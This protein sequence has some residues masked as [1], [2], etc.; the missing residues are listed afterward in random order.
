MA[1]APF[2]EDQL[3]S[4]VPSVFSRDTYRSHL[5]QC[6]PDEVPAQWLAWV[7]EDIEQ[8]QTDELEILAANAGC[9]ASCIREAVELATPIDLDTQRSVIK[10][11]AILYEVEEWEPQS[12]GQSLRVRAG[13]YFESM[14]D[15]LAINAA[16]WLNESM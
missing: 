7:V 3:R 14:H 1:K 2:T 16:T 12:D 11:L 9:F 10:W 5:T 6:L 8:R 13:R 15:R 4:I